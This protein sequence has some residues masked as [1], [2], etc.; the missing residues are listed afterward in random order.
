MARDDSKDRP[1]SP[2]SNAPLSGVTLAMLG[3]DV[4]VDGVG[5]VM[6]VG[7]SVEGVRHCEH[8][9]PLHQVCMH[10]CSCVY[11]QM[12]S[13]HESV[14]NTPTRKHT[15]THPHANTSVWN[16]EARSHA[17]TTGCA[18][19]ARSAKTAC[20]N[21]KSCATCARIAK[22]ANTD[23]PRYAISK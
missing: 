8:K 2:V 19:T 12:M 7:G 16:V 5:G 4:S 15:H 18:R 17:S 13:H 14:A 11:E 1:P 22:S 20:V 21:T 10:V 3:G 23:F 6:G 9:K